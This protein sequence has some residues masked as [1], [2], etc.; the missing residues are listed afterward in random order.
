MCA[1]LVT[2]LKAVF[3]A[4]LADPTEPLTK[5]AEPLTKLDV[6]AIDLETDLDA[7]L[8]DRDGAAKEVLLPIRE[9]INRVIYKRNLLM[10]E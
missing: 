2:D 4:P 10:R 5:R 7:L 3:D 8:T 6:L 1:K 9:L